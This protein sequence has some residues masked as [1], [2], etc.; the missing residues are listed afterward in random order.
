MSLTLSL[1]VLMR[2]FIFLTKIFAKWEFDWCDQKVKFLTSTPPVRLELG[3]TI[4]KS[5]TAERIYPCSCKSNNFARVG[6]LPFYTVFNPPGPESAAE[7]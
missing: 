3:Y 1:H 2:P 4:I 7:G 6:I 5:K